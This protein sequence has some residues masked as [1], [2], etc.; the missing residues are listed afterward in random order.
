MW[1]WHIGLWPVV[2][3]V[4]LRAVADLVV[5]RGVRVARTPAAP[6]HRLLRRPRL[7]DRTLF[8]Y[9]LHS[10]GLHRYGLQSYGTGRQTPL[11]PTPR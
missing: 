11:T 6:V 3:R 10:Y 9:A 8:A 4:G 1:L 2:W 7:D 5:L